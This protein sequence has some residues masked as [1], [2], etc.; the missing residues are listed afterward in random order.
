MLRVGQEVSPFRSYYFYYAAIIVVIWTAILWSMP[1]CGKKSGE[2]V[3]PGS[4]QLHPGG[5]YALGFSADGTFFYTTGA[6]STL[7]WETASHQLLCSLPPADARVFTPDNKNLILVQGNRAEFRRARDCKLLRGFSL[8]NPEGGE[9]HQVE[10]DSSGKYLAGAIFST[11]GRI[12]LWDASDTDRAGKQVARAET[13]FLARK[14]TLSPDGEFLVSPEGEGALKLRSLPDLKEISRSPEDPGHAVWNPAFSQNGHWLV[15]HKTTFTEVKTHS[16]NLVLWKAADL[17]LIT[18]LPFFTEH[19]ALAPDGQ[20]LALVDGDNTTR[21]FA[22]PAGKESGRL[23]QTNP[24]RT[25][26]RIECLKAGPDDLLITGHT[27]G[28]VRIWDS[29]SGR[30]LRTL[31][32]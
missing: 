7:L 22:L 25:N 28:M 31:E 11:S 3:A 14:F 23:A 18:T 17:K 6:D 13:G 2:P 10:I 24:S 20:S 8:E 1:A 12:L 4:R 15:A 26:E 30:L 32:K 19:F 27:G 21:L 9:I 29:K 5:V 16:A